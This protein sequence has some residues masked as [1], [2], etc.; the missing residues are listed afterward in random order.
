MKFMDL[1]EIGLDLNNPMVWDRKILD[2]VIDKLEFKLANLEQN[3]TQFALAARFEFDG[4]DI[5][6][7]VDNGYIEVMGSKNDGS[8]CLGFTQI[9]DLNGPDR[10]F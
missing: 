5:E 7:V 4:S 3:Y 6:I 8:W 2:K 1:V 10:L 9:D